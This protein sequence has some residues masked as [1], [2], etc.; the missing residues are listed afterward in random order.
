M[1]RGNQRGFTL[2]EL[3]IVVAIIGILAAVA[4]PAYDNYT[5]KARFS[6]VVTIADGYKTPVVVCY[7]E[8]GALANCDG[9]ANGVP[10]NI[11]TGAAGQLDSLTVTDGVITATDDNGVT[12]ILT[13][14]VNG[15]V[16]NWAKSGTCTTSTP[17]LC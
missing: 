7:M 17:P 8:T 6:E 10:A 15:A 16:I 2:I 13:P 9:G 5:Q 11:A 12:Y 3:M 1:K 4:I 14:T